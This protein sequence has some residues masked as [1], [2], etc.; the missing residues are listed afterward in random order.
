ME[1]RR[2]PA[3]LRR[4]TRR[5]SRV[6]ASPLVTRGARALDAYPEI[7]V[8]RAARAAGT[9]APGP[10]PLRALEGQA[11][12]RGGAVGT[13]ARPR[14]KSGAPRATRVLGGTAPS[15]RH[16]PPSGRVRVGAAVAPVGASDQ[17]AMVAVDLHPPRAA[18]ATTDAPTD[19]ADL[20]AG[21]ARASGPATLPRCGVFGPGVP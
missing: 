21:A 3:P 14:P 20:Q 1:P 4:E 10:R 16:R 8:P 6:V 5:A 17:G 18:V 19:V 11:A 7:T 12:T 2:V 9:V 15:A 13:A